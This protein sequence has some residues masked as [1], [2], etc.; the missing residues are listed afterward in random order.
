MGTPVSVALGWPVTGCPGGHRGLLHHH[1]GGGHAEYPSAG[2][3]P[4]PAAQD[5]A[6]LLPQ[7]PLDAG[8]VGPRGPLHAG[9]GPGGGQ[10]TLVCAWWPMQ[11][12]LL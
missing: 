10:L 12:L 4:S 1:R 5:K 3:P 7:M 9:A 6:S 11:P 8:S 2:P